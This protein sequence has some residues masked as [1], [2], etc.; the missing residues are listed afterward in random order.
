M[1]LTFAVIAVAAAQRDVLTHDKS[2]KAAH[3]ASCSV[4]SECDTSG[5]NDTT[6]QRGPHGHCYCDKACHTQFNDCCHDMKYQ[7]YNG[8]NDLCPST[9]CYE[10]NETWMHGQDTSIVCTMNNKDCLK[11]TCSMTGMTVKLDPELFHTNAENSATFAQQLENGDRNLKMDGVA[12]TSSQWS[13][14][15]GF[16]VVDIDYSTYGITPTLD[17]TGP[18]KMINYGV[19]FISEGNAGDDSDVIEFYVDTTVNA[20]CSYPADVMIEADGFW[21]NQEDVEM[22]LSEEGQLSSQC[23][24]KFFANSD[25]DNQI[26]SHNIVNMGEM[27]YGEV[28]CNEMHGLSYELTKVEVSDPKDG[29]NLY[30]VAAAANKAT[31]NYSV[32]PADAKAATGT[33]IDFEYLSFGFE[34]YGGGGNQNEV[35]VKCFVTLT[36]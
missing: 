1:K 2:L 3:H 32:T 10:Q 19:Q 27:L 26:M 24:C 4:N 29:N 31:V 14:S 36:V 11:T 35:N 12:L 9:K 8:E 22:D 30:D 28:S 34:S 20:D 25:R 17:T 16:I 18:A 33:D 21:V 13:T 23:H 6:I 5:R 7:C 15:N